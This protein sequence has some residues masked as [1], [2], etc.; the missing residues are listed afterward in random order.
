[1]SVDNLRTRLRAVVAAGFA[2]PADGGAFALAHTALDALASPDP[3]LRDEL[4]IEVLGQWIQN[5]VLST[6]ETH[7][8]LRRAQSDTMLFAAIGERGT[9]SVFLR[10]FSLLVIAVALMRDAA[11]PYLA[12]KD[13]R[14]TRGQLLR[15]CREENDLR[16]YVPGNGWAHAIA[17]TADVVDSL[18]VS[19]RASSKDC[20]DLF[21]ALRMLINRADEVFQG[22]EDERIA[23]AIAAMLRRGT[24][25][26]SD[27]RAWFEAEAPTT[28]TADFE[29][30][31]RRV[32]WKLVA[33]SL[34]L[35]LEKEQPGVTDLAGL[36]SPF[37]IY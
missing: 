31:V 18:V 30:R 37:S 22:E 2:A 21:E 11:E 5:G 24:V 25:T 28:Q 33:R 3:A 29:A 35:R 4:A 20:R 36:D 23:I 27:L 6:T 16:A 10:T 15:Y 32:N 34:L 26:T 1:M 9:T 14:E 17:H 7:E 8:L 13:W 12:D 19:R